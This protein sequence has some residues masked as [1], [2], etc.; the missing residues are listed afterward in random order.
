MRDLRADSSKCPSWAAVISAWWGQGDY[1]CHICYTN[2]RIIS[3]Y[4]LT[5][6]LRRLPLRR[7]T[8]GPA[9][10]NP[11][12]RLSD[13]TSCKDSS[14]ES[15]LTR[16]SVSLA[17]A[18]N[19]LLYEH[20]VRSILSSRLA[21]S[22]FSLCS[23]ARRPLPL[24]QL[25]SLGFQYLQRTRRVWVRYEVLEALEQVQAPKNCDEVQ[26]GR[27]ASPLKPL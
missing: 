15:N 25:G 17:S 12:P 2:K 26:Q 18:C 8:R 21:C 14:A 24:P 4:Q 11:E 19:A 23:R 20:I 22:L 13:R 3:V 10:F 5:R 6:S 9:V 7:G 16:G 27:A 1:G